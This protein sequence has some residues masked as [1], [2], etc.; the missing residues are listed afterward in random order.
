MAH[1]INNSLFGGVLKRGWFITFVFAL[2]DMS[3]KLDFFVC[4]ITINE[5]ICSLSCVWF[6][7]PVPFIDLRLRTRA[8][9][10]R[11][12]HIEVSHFYTSVIYFIASL[13]L[14]TLCFIWLTIR[15]WVHHNYFLI[16][17]IKKVLTNE[18]LKQWP[19]AQGWGYLFKLK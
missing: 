11:T 13:T 3:L 5:D 7:R 12:C 18:N 9:R 15:I 16:I 19:I 17:I 2:K 14:F 1:Q 8:E 4:T 6:H 10:N